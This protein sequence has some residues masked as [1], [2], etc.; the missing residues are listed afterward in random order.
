MNILQRMDPNYGKGVFR[1]RLRLQVQGDGSGP[2]GL[3]GLMLVDLED[4]NHAF[5]IRLQHDGVVVTDVLS[6]SVRHPFT[7]C[8]DASQPLRRA[9]GLRLDADGLTQRQRLE[10]GANCTHLFDMTILALAHAADVGLDRLYEITIDDER[11]GLIRSRIECNGETIHDWQVRDQVVEAPDAYAGQP[12]MRGFYAWASQAF[13]GMPLEAAVA[14]QR[15]FFVGQ[16]RRYVSRP[17][18]LYPAISDGVPDGVC[19]S[20]NHG[21]VERA[22]RINGSI[23][24]HSDSPDRLLKFDPM[25]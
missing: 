14:L 4:N 17:I 10:P 23:R 8:P 24:D 5:R 13:T 11:D 6:E 22:L 15:G 7:T 9:I 12:I 25:P 3:G 21:V 19:Y 16:S 1:R 20:Y 2:A 18:E